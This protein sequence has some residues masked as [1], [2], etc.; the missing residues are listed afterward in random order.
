MLQWGR[1]GLVADGARVCRAVFSTLKPSACEWLAGHG[2]TIVARHILVRCNLLSNRYLTSCERITAFLHHCAARVAVETNLGRCCR[3]AD[4]DTQHS[5]VVNQA[6]LPFWDRTHSPSRL[7]ARSYLV[8]NAG[9]VVSSPET[10]RASK[11]VWISSN[12]R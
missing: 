5:D 10:T 12:R 1:D 9:Y 4:D 7:R 3:T 11:R 6:A 2:E 8:T